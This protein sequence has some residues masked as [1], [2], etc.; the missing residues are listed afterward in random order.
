MATPHTTSTPKVKIAV[1]VFRDAERTPKQYEI[2]K[3]C[4]RGRLK[5]GEKIPKGVAWQ[6]V[7]ELVNGVC[8]SKLPGAL[9]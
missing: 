4:S 6:Y 1:C 8:P 9:S 5:E 3:D 7:P 2:C